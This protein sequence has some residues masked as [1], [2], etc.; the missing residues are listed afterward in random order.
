MDISR[1]KIF[2]SSLFFLFIL[3]SPWLF[4]Q[5]RLPKYVSDGMVIQRNASVKIWGWADAAEKIKV[6][7]IA[8][9]SGLL[10]SIILQLPVK[11]ENGK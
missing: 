2:R 1:R 5:I 3:I 4:G 6:R 10:I 8:A 9:V 7:F 11:M